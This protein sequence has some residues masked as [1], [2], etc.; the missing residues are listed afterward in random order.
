MHCE[1]LNTWLNSRI[2]SNLI[3]N[4]LDIDLDLGTHNKS[5][6]LISQVEISWKSNRVYIHMI[7]IKLHQVL[8]ENVPQLDIDAQLDLESQ[9]RNHK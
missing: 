5:H 4:D 2:W 6:Y 9:I 1:M 3:S 8:I 7:A